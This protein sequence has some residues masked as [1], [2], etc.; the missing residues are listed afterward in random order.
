MSYSRSPTRLEGT[1]VAETAQKSKSPKGEQDLGLKLSMRR[2]FWGMNYATRLNLLLALPGSRRTADELSDLDCVGFSVGGDFSVRLLIADCKSGGKVSPA[3]RLFWLAGV[4]DFFG[5]DRAYAV[6]SRDI[7]EGARQQAAGLGLDAL[8]EADRQ[9]LENV[10]WPLAPA[11]PFFEIEGAVKLQGFA[12]GLDK[13]LE[14]LVRFRDHEYWHLPPERRI[15]RLIGALRDAAPVLDRSQRAHAV[16]VVDLLFL[17]TLSLLGACRYVS[18]ISLSNPRRALLQYLL[19]GPELARAREKSLDVLAG[20]LKDLGKHGVE[21]PDE[22][23]E[24]MSIEP[25]Y[26]DALAETVTRMLRRPRDAQRLLRYLEWYGQAEVG[27]GGPP[28]E[29][30]LGPVY[31]EY[32][33]KLVT[34]IARM[35]FGAAGLDRAWLA[36]FSAGPAALKAGDEP[37]SV[38]ASGSV[39]LPLDPE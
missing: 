20:A 10:H 8:G 29:D 4:R 19:G 17:L 25:A 24:Q 13:R 21:V 37:L 9:I 30:A 39:Q 36:L 5:A 2:V 27:L 35:C 14:R 7:P 3:S 26:F 16:L 12:R 18:S 11:A 22:I 34:D 1:G 15:Q 33:R 38:P 28:A 31:G 6:M 23:L 32:T